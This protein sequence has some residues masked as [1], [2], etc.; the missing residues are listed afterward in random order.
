MLAWKGR[1]ESR[2]CLRTSTGHQTSPAVAQTCLPASLL[3]LTPPPARKQ[4][5]IAFRI[6]NVRAIHYFQARAEQ[7]DETRLGAEAEVCGLA[8][9]AGHTEVFLVDPGGRLTFSKSQSFGAAFPPPTLSMG[10]ICTGSIP[11]RSTHHAS[12]IMM[13]LSLSPSQSSSGQRGQGVGRFETTTASNVAY[14]PT[15]GELP[16]HERVAATAYPTSSRPTSFSLGPDHRHDRLL[17]PPSHTASP[18]PRH[19]IATSSE[20][21]HD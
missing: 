1:I 13:K 19:L 21:S 10:R 5:H 11:S 12:C 15:V 2:A 3:F 16:N 9:T 6:V 20:Q 14:V 8:K 18:T 4:E 7:E 17:G